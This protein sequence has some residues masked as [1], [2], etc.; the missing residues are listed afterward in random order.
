MPDIQN[1][2]TTVIEF[3]VISSFVLLALDYVVNSTPPL[4][5]VQLQP[6]PEALSPLAGT[7]ETIV[8]QVSLST[9]KQIIAPTSIVVPTLTAN[10]NLNS[11]SDDVDPWLLPSQ[12]PVNTLIFEAAPQPLRLLPP[13]HQQLDLSTLKLYK[14]HKH[15]VVRV[16]DIRT[17]LPPGLKSYKLHGKQVVRLAELESAIA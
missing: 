6:K 5:P 3:V 10:A 8:L 4:P 12:L 11:T 9:D 15:S 14:L 16:E 13:A 7:E 1:F 17:A 2:L